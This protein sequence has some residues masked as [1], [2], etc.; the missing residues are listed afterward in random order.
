MRYT[1]PSFL[2]ASRSALAD[3]LHVPVSEIVIIQN[4]TSGVNLVLRNLEFQ[5]HDV[6]IYFDTIYGAC[7]KTLVSLLETEGARIGLQIRKVSY[8]LPRD[9]HDA[10]VE[11]FSAVLRECEND[12]LNVKVAIFDTIASL[13]GVRLPFERLVQQCRKQGILSLVDAAHGIGQIPL[14]LGSLDADFF[15][16]NCHK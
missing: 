6:I 10:L 13:P 7:E 8:E 3:L 1:Y 9:G 14:D 5:K 4:A 15:V 2:D 11:S 16:S 12:G